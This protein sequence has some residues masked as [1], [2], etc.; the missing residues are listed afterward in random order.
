MTDPKPIEL[1][2]SLWRFEDTCNVYVLRDGDR[3]I[4]IDFG[5]GR[6]MARLPELGIGKL[7]HVFLTHHH[8]DQCAGL[9][10]K[11][12]LPFA[13]H[14]PMGEEAFLEPEKVKA[15]HSAPWYGRGC[16]Q[17][18][19]V[20]PEGIPGVR[21]NMDWCGDIFWGNR[22]IRFVL[23]PGHGPYACSVILDQQGRQI[24]FCG[25]AAHDGGTLWQPF[26]LEWDHYTGGGAL[27]AWEGIMRLAGVGMD[28]LCPSH[29]PVIDQKPAQALQLL[30]R[31][32][33]D[34]FKAKGSV[35]PGEKD[36][37]VEPVIRPSGAKEVLPH[38][39]QFGGN[40]Y[41]LVSS[42]GE[43]LIV[44][45]CL[46]DVSALKALL[47]ELGNIRPTAMAVSHY[48]CDHC[49]AIPALRDRYGAKAWLHPKIAEPLADPEH[50]I[51]PWLPPFPIH[52][53]HLWPEEGAWRWQE[54]SFAVSHWPG[55]T[56]GHC[57][58]MASVDGQK[59][60][61]GGDSFQPASRWSG[62]GG[63]CAYNKSRFRDGY[64]PSACL[65]LEWSPD[66]IATGHGTFYRYAPSQFRKIIRWAESAEKAVRALCP[67][68]DLEKDYCI[69][70]DI[71][72]Q[73][74]ALRRDSWA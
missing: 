38:L 13:V 18:Y 71:L 32:L 3:A 10:G 33:M 69:V 2:P 27:A 65:A 36:R 63:F 6:W 53:D 17:S 26:H 47:A 9:L 64:I 45:P 5:S 28:L 20:P 37:Y 55:Q 43:A 48:H 59:V 19:L 58:F 31:R 8:T 56:W 73:N 44:D 15:Y 57:V 50:T 16:P 12:D 21:C 74:A 29:G 25:D 30:S 72:A 46:G 54:Y 68:G 34:F 62:T 23:T 39:Y 41:L 60:L 49:D 22:R 67:S 61:F 14:A 4:A 40:G 42:S 66:I 11:A 51:M 7:E 52:P 35:C 1:L 24:V 70:H